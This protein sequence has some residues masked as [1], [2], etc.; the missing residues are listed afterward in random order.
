MRD[1]MDEYLAEVSSAA[2]EIRIMQGIN[3]LRRTSRK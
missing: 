2:M 3:S 1:L